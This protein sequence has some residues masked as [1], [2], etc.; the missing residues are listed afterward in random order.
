MFTIKW[1]KM[2]KRKSE[3]RTLVWKGKIA[4]GGIDVSVI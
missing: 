4:T 2:G 3:V 1:R